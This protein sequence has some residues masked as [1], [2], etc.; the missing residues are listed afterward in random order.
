MTRFQNKWESLALFGVIAFS[1]L[2]WGLKGWGFSGTPV[3]KCLIQDDS[4][5]QEVVSK[6]FE[7]SAQS[8][9]WIN[10]E[11]FINKKD[12]TEE[13]SFD[14]L[15][16]LGG[17][18]PAHR[19]ID[20]PLLANSVV[21]QNNS[22]EKYWDPSWK[23]LNSRYRRNESLLKIWAPD[24]HMF[25]GDYKPISLVNMF[26]NGML[27]VESSE[28]IFLES[29][30]S[31]V[32]LG[33]I[34]PKPYDTHKGN[35]IYKVVP[36]DI[37]ILLFVRA[38][39]FANSVVNSEFGKTGNRFELEYDFLK[40]A[41]ATPRD[42]WPKVRDDFSQQI[43]GICSTDSNPENCLK[44]EELRKTA[45][46]DY[47][48]RSELVLQCHEHS[49]A[50]SGHFGGD[51]FWLQKISEFE[52]QSSYIPS[53]GSI[54]VSTMV[55][56]LRNGI[57]TLSGR[58]L[59]QDAK[60]LQA[61]KSCLES[62]PDH[63][64][65]KSDSEA[66]S[67]PSKKLS[68][69]ARKCIGALKQR[70]VG[71]IDQSL[72]SGIRDPRELLSYEIQAMAQ[73]VF[74]QNGKKRLD[75]SRY[76]SLNKETSDD[77]LLDKESEANVYGVLRDILD[78]GD[79][80]HYVSL[81]YHFFHMNS[82]LPWSLNLRWH[83]GDTE[84]C[85]ILLRKK[86]GEDDAKLRYFGSECTQ[87][88]YGTS[89]PNQW[90][91][92][93][94]ISND[95]A[96]FVSTNGEITR[97]AKP[98]NIYVSRGSHALN[99]LPGYHI[100]GSNQKGPLAAQRGYH[101]YGAS[102]ANDK[103]APD[104]A[105]PEQLAVTSS[106]GVLGYIYGLRDM[107]PIPGV[108][109]SARLE[110]PA[111]KQDKLAII[112]LSPANRRWLNGQDEETLPRKNNS[113]RTTSSGRGRAVLNPEDIQQGIVDPRN[114]LYLL[115]TNYPDNAWLW[116]GFSDNDTHFFFGGASKLPG[117]SGPPV[118]RQATDIPG[119]SFFCNPVDHYFYYYRPTVEI[120]KLAADLGTSEEAVEITILNGRLY[121]LLDELP[122]STANNQIRDQQLQ[123][124]TRFVKT[125][126]PLQRRFEKLS[127]KSKSFDRKR[128]RNLE[129][130]IDALTRR[131]LER[132]RSLISQVSST[133]DQ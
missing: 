72:N 122:T 27:T 55:E 66:S 8:R 45:F 133:L 16:F 98:F 51:Q 76:L 100:S 11:F 77:L 130:N 5:T 38:L 95:P 81:Q 7:K 131:E 35:Y 25:Y 107:A 114:Q 86:L 65:P 43:L 34:D 30:N 89:Y 37:S 73:E 129:N 2:G 52:L 15:I 71:W 117:G 31:D 127:A 120:A 10:P 90:F 128:V 36:K 26:R 70:R 123:A 9:L 101:F 23:A 24:L 50:K 60:F 69:N 53:L 41:G 18:K 121:R 29:L 62:D 47:L 46:E 118:P 115:H 44:Q 105:F 17:L 49:L 108:H 6:A 68:A 84:K 88:Y 91:S 12:S 20:L 99:F 104:S 79:G 78:T 103:T 64:L 109:P 96:A 125:F 57:T 3:K 59:K 87:H 83:D 124:S 113:V 63:L 82:F 42:Q 19:N 132:I 93:E 4:W 92:P 56:C 97:R 106:P 80:Y 1:T 85:Q 102:N 74:D 67:E 28:P 111:E 75:I 58:Y 32:V 21:S 48:F 126:V 40:S 116:N 61:Q 33:K 13:R 22:D 39:R 112:K 54:K 14:Y 110:E 94:Q 119:R